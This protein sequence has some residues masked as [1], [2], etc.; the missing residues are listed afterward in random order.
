MWLYLPTSVVSRE[1]A[2]S[3]SPSDSLC[4]TL[5]ASAMWRQKFLL[6][7]IWRLVLRKA[8]LM[9]RLSGLTFEPSTAQRGVD[10]W[11]ESLR[12]SRAPI[13]PSPAD[14]QES[15]ESTA[16]S[17]MTSAAPFGT[18]DPNGCIWRTSQASLFHIP[19][20][21]GE[22]D[23]ERRRWTQYRLPA[24]LWFVLG[25]LALLGFDAEWGCLS[26][27]QTG[28]PHKRNR[29]FCLAYRSRRG[30]GELRQSSGFGGGD[31]LTGAIKIWKTPH[32]MGGMDASGK[33]GG[34]GGGEF[35]KQAN[36]WNV[37]E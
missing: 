27:A 1:S 7:R 6:P 21:A 11:M 37:D 18:L 22:W 17:G 3:T 28:A 14:E 2:D 32:G 24:G 23:R 12:V 9:M 15:S 33:H 31:S 34:A 26:A 5:A 36:E 4:Q 13:T 10:S 8:A 25:D 20:A 19:S 35:A 30:L 16:N 29:W